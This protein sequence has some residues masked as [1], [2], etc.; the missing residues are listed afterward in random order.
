VC[1]CRGGK[2]SDARPYE[3]ATLIAHKVL[4]DFIAG[5]PV[6]C[7]QVDYDARNN[8]PVARC[9]AGEDDLQAM[10]VSAA[11][12]GPSVNTASGTRQRKRKQRRAKP[13]CTATGAF[14][15]G[16]GGTST[17]GSQVSPT[18][19]RAGEICPVS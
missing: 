17:G 4:E 3:L 14:R 9:F 6:T 8:R 18:V 1:F 13:V 19:R 16:I 10:M 7:K 2:R 11:G 5:R 15:H 12:R